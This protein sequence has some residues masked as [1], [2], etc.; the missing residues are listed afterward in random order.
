MRLV[1]LLFLA[2][3]LA[4]C[5]TAPQLPKIESSRGDRI[6]VLVEVGGNPAHT[7]V[8][9]TVFNNFVKKYPYQWNLGVDVRRTIERSVKEAGFTVVDLRQEGFDYQKV[10]GLIQATGDQ[11][12]VAAGKKEIFR[13][14]R[15][16]HKLKALIVVKDA[17]V[18]ATLECGGGP[19]TERYVDHSGLYTRS[20]FGY[21][22]YRA[23]AAFPW[24]VYVLDPVADIAKAEPLRRSL[25]ESSYFLRGFK[26]PADFENLT[27]AE[28]A[29][30]RDGIL[31]FTQEASNAVVRAL[32]V[33]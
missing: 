28:F 6:G 18:V 1:S 11:W 20:V 23:V 13:Q 4:G 14:L 29:P 19:C 7:H 33:K 25:G 31:S 26:S 17:R 22:S 2:A 24:E 5:A 15:E 16:Q 3:M 21:T 27:E 30:V 32:N 9:T 12:Q 8:G 10:T